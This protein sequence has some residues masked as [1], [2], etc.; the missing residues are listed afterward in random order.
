MLR[1]EIATDRRKLGQKG[2]GKIA[3][4]NWKKMVEKR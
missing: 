3:G 1:S 4:Q 2:K